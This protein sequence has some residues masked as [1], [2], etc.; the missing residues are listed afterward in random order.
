MTNQIINESGMISVEKMLNYTSSSQS[1]SPTLQGSILNGYAGKEGENPCAIDD[2]EQKEMADVDQNKFESLISLYDLN[3]EYFSYSNLNTIQEKNINTIPNS[4]SIQKEIHA[5]L[6][7]FLMM[8][9][10]WKL[11]KFD[12]KISKHKLVT[13]DNLKNK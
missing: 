12:H 1:S 4:L 7:E 11:R 10:N 6:V 3:S 9:N 2:E 5:V 13:S 8:L